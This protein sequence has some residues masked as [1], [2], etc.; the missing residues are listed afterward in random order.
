M[1]IIC[2]NCLA[3]YDSE[4]FLDADM[5][6]V[7]CPCCQHTEEFKVIPGKVLQTRKREFRHVSEIYNKHKD[8]SRSYIYKLLKRSFPEDKWTY[9]KF[10]D[11]LDDIISN[12]METI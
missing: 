2:E 4:V 7:T 6:C 3:Q 1:L 8:K 5:E 11:R 12:E 9:G 10:K